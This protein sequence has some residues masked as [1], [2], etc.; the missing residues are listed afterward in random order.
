MYKVHVFKTVNCTQNEAR[1]FPYN[2]RMQKHEINHVR[3][4]V[5]TFNDKVLCHTESQEQNNL[6]I[7]FYSTEWEAVQ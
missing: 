3:I 1:R 5:N 6:I 2:Q 4:I 7:C